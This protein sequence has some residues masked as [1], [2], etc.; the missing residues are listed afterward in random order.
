VRRAVV[1]LFVL[2]AA[3]GGEDPAARSFDAALAALRAGDLDR[4]RSAAEAAA[5]E[6]GPAFA[7]ARDFVR[8]N[9]AFARSEAAEAA[10]A[11]PGA[12]PTTMEAARSFAEDALAAWRS[13]ASSRAD[14]PAARR[15]VE[16]ALLRLARLR[17][18]KSAGGKEGPKPPTPKDAPP[19]LPPP[20]PP[21]PKDP[22]A[23]LPAA[24]DPVDLPPERVAALLEV[25]RKKEAERRDVRK[26]TR[27][28]TSRGVERDW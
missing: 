1:L 27:R 20:L 3:C 28:E 18:K 22:P 14:W 16:R 24:Y 21:P 7:G 17:E 13:A 6:G 5:T 2:L 23:D 15:N 9:V 11:R 26:A 10:A 4:A 19:D 12:D 8:G 25:L